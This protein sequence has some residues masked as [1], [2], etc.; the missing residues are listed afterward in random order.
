MQQIV[1]SPIFHFI[2][3]VFGNLLQL[4]ALLLQL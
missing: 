2:L 1:Q 3:L 4:N